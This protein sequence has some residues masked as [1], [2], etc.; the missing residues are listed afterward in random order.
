MGGKA[1][2][3]T[4]CHDIRAVLQCHYPDEAQTCSV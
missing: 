4:A 2:A 1:R 3:M